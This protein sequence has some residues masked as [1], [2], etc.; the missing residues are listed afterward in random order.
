MW[1]RVALIGFSGSGKTTTAGRL[2]QLTGWPAIDIDEDLERHFGT[3]IP[4]VFAN[5]GEDVFR[6]AE[7]AHLVA[8]CARD[9][10]I[11]ATGGG[12]SAQPSA[13][14]AGLLGNPA[15][16][17]VALDADPEI[18]LRRLRNQQAE[19]GAAYTRPMIEG[20]DPLTR[21]ARLKESRQEAYDRAQITLNVDYTSAETIAA[22]IKS[23]LDQT[24]DPASP[25]VTLRAPG[26]DSRI[27]VH[28]GLLAKAGVLIRNAFPRSIRSWVISDAN[29]ATLHGPALKATL[30]QHDFEVRGLTV[31]PG[32]SSKSLKTAGELY[33]QMLDGG[34]E[35]SDIVVALGGGVIGDLA[36]YI[37]ATVLRGIGLVQVPTSLLAMVDSSAGGKTGINHRAGKNL[38]GAFYQPPLVLI[39]P[40]TLHTLPPRELHQGWAEVI[41]HAVIQPSTPGGERADLFCFLQRNA[42]HLLALDEPATSYLIRRNVE[43]KS[44]VVEADERESGIR[45][46][47]NFGHTLGHAIEA[48]NYQH[49][50]GEAIAL[51]LRAAAALSVGAN[52]ADAGS[53]RELCDLLDRYHLPG[54]SEID[55]HR[56][57]ELIKSDKKRV[58]GSQ[59]WVLMKRNGGVEIREDVDDRLVL[60]ALETI[61]AGVARGG[62]D[63]L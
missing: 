62:R 4:K 27:F 58:H 60:M 19:E 33:D 10:V 42:D 11:I 21:I 63:L 55:P 15:T 61:S 20:D 29:V 57:L 12:A 41:K 47:L 51:G 38:I 32:E 49:L 36:G 53:A 30:E 52:G 50:H 23:L 59:R 1:Q 24:L 48:S 5:Q 22:E 40:L 35:R 16:L 31:N 14:T 56:V 26:G 28:Q 8:A 2:S 43:L 34:V 3:T 46:Y 39:D 25:S 45:A 6:Q 9:Q 54:T 13:W 18:S 37:A 17:T 44:R 7:R